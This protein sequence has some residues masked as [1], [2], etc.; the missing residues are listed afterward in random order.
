MR[1]LATQTRTP[2]TEQPDAAPRTPRWAALTWPILDPDRWGPRHNRFVLLASGVV[3]VAWMVEVLQAD[4]ASSANGVRAAVGAAVGMAL[5]GLALSLRGVTVPGLALGGFV[6]F[7]GL[8][9]AYQPPVLWTVYALGAV[10]L[11]LWTF[12]WFRDALVFPRLGTFYLGVVLWPLGVVGAVL[13]ANWRIGGERVAYLGLAAVT[14]LAAVVAVR[15]TR[16]DISVG[17]VAAFLLAIA[18]LVLVGSGNV[19]DD[20]HAVPDNPWGAAMQARF[21][22]GPG[23]L[24]HPNFLAA[25]GVIVAMRIAPARAF[26]AWQRG[27][28]LAV[29]VLVCVLTNSRTGLV[30]AATAVFV[31]AV[32]VWRQHRRQRAETGGP[33]D[34][35]P[36]YSTGRRAVAAALLPVALVGV[37]FVGQGGVASLTQSRY[38]AETDETG[39][40]VTS[41]RTETWKRVL[42]DFRADT[43][44]EKAVGNSDHARGVVIRDT[45]G[46]VADRPK[47]ATD[48]AAVGALRRGGVLGV[49]AFLVGL[50]LLLYHAVR[51]GAPAWLT[52]SAIAALP[53]LMVSDWLLGGVAGTLWIYLAAAE[54]WIVLGR[55]AS[56]PEPVEIA[57]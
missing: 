39:V 31:H 17:V 33:D 7:C 45:T 37:L 24:Y 19:L 13:T 27:A 5:V 15:R 12:P 23:L 44:V 25:L 11:A 2:S 35:L 46:P 55:P 53:T 47:L 8:I 14:I 50:G 51:R 16:R 34:G 32:L 21:W 56:E 41:G 6:V 43:V 29:V 30:F 57:G 42:A 36:L 49:V 40:D 18:L 52:I 3:L 28:V 26:R 20:L 1:A 9:S 4:V 38:P 22:G 54:A 48:N 10:A